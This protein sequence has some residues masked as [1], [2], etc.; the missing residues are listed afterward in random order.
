ME[1]MANFFSSVT[2]GWPSE[3]HAVENFVNNSEEM[4]NLRK[5]ARK[6][7]EGDGAKHAIDEIKKAKTFAELLNATERVDFDHTNDK[8]IQK[9]GPKVV[10]WGFYFASYL[11][12]QAAAVNNL[13]Q[14][15]QKTEAEAIR[16]NY[17]TKNP[18]SAPTLTA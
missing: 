11:S 8:F 12:N 16:L 13:I 2:Q 1:R 17:S 5:I 4:A 10:K 9:I 6:L 7:A 15:R 14:F 18:I 3:K